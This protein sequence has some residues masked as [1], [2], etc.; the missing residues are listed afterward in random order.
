M[1]HPVPVQHAIRMH[2]FPLTGM[3]LRL[4]TVKQTHGGAQLACTGIGGVLPA[5][6]V[7]SRVLEKF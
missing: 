7:R 6:Q 5:R 2:V 1:A 3:I 4:A